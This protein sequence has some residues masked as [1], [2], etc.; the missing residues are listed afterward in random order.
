MDKLRKD[1]LAVRY[2]TLLRSMIEEGRDT[3]SFA[4][5]V[6]N[7]IYRKVYPDLDYVENSLAKE[8]TLFEDYMRNKP[9]NGNLPSK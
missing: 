1:K 8:E 7:E 9:S 2:T 6:G 5:T 4:L 3:E